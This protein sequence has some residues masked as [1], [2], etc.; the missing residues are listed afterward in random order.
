MVVD[1]SG[2]PVEGAEVASRIDRMVTG[3]DGRFSLSMGKGACHG[4]D[5]WISAGGRGLSAAFIEDVDEVSQP[6]TIRVEPA[7][8]T[9]SGFVRTSDGAPVAGAR[10]EG[11]PT[12]DGVVGTDADGRFVFDGCPRE[13]EF[14]LCAG[15]PGHSWDEVKVDA[16]AGTTNLVLTLEPKTA[17]TLRVEGS[18]VDEAGTGVAGARVTW[19]S[20]AKDE[21]SVMASA[22]GSFVLDAARWSEPSA[23]WL[24]AE[25]AGFLSAG[26]VPVRYQESPMPAV[27]LALAR[28]GRVRGRVVDALDGSPIARMSVQLVR[29]RGKPEAHR[30]CH[31]GTTNESGTFDFEAP[32]GVFDLEVPSSAHE[33]HPPV[34]VVVTPGLA[35]DAGTAK[36]I[37][38]G[39]IEGVVRAATDWRQG[40]VMIVRRAPGSRAFE[41]CGSTDGLGWFRAAHVP[42]GTW[43]IFGVEQSDLSWGGSHALVHAALV[44]TVTVTSGSTARVDAA[45]PE[46]ASLTIVA[47]AEGPPGSAVAITPPVLVTDAS[48][49][50]PS[51]LLTEG[52][53]EMVLELKIEALDGLPFMRTDED[54]E[55]FAAVTSGWHLEGL[56]AEFQMPNLAAGRYRF[57]IRRKGC[58][59]IERIVRLAAGEKQWLVLDLDAK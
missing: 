21:A 14:S 49:R 34:Q 8:V 2:R 59:P 57:S 50:P 31:C 55:F 38:K 51:V 25:A 29:D 12:A 4:N 18:V 52:E 23:M 37:P 56:A 48:G 40:Q 16:S 6:V 43:E 20:H 17:W 45:M 10:V 35:T 39:G 58:A 47:K 28:G 27:R 53:R 46:P 22:D 54:P 24:K 19:C 26:Y 44:G 41:Y 36:L 3:A 5:R 42:P 32:G 9:L 33:D 15:A 30:L 13:S 1:S 7:D 11:H